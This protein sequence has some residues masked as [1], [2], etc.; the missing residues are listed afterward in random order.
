MIN[1]QS[2][3]KKK[4]TQKVLKYKQEAY[5]SKLFSYIT[6][7]NNK[8]KYEKTTPISS[9]LKL[10][11]NL[12]TSLITGLT[13]IICLCCILPTPT[14][15]IAI[16]RNR[17]VSSKLEPLLWTST[18]EK[19]KPTSASNYLRLN[20]QIGDNIDLVCPK[21]DSSMDGL[22]YLTIYKVGSKEE[23]DNCIINPNNRQTV[24]ILRCDKP[25]SAV[26]FTLFFIKFS[27]VPFALEFEE[28]KEYYFLT[29]SSGEQKGLNYMTGGLCNKFNMKFSIKISSGEAEVTSTQQQITKTALT[30]SKK[31]HLE[32]GETRLP[33]KMNLISRSSTSSALSFNFYILN[34]VF[35]LI[36]SSV[37]FV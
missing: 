7:E 6:K 15:A 18:N 20:G 25:Q 27:P 35:V 32:G 12:N 16:L 1:N 5:S 30:S 28:D 22:N 17:S 24:P 10:T 21:S 19:F 3:K 36:L 11:M 26:K 2:M 31:F 8:P 34:S 9:T 13:L 4:S 33:S 23:F 37:I 14:S 29:T